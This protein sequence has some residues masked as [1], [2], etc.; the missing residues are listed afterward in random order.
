MKKVTI[1]IV[2][3]VFAM[4]LAACNNGGGTA[5]DAGGAVTPTGDGGATT[6]VTD[7]TAADTPHVWRFWF[8]GTT[9]PY[10]V[11]WMDTDVGRVVQERTGVTVEIEFIV[12]EVEERAA[13]VVAAGDFPDFSYAWHAFDIFRD[14]GAIIPLNDLYEEHAPNIQN[15]W[16]TH[17]N[18]LK[19]PG[20]EILWGLAAM[21]FN[22]P[23]LDYP[24]AGF[25]MRASAAEFHGWR[26]FT[27]PDDFFQAIREYV[28]A[29][30]YND[31]GQSNIGFSGPAEGWR[32]G[33]SMQGGNRLHG[34][35][36]TGGLFFDPNNNWEGLHI[37]TSHVRHDYLV[38]LWELNQ[39]GLLDPEFLS[40]D[41]DGYVAKIASGRVVGFYD[42]FW[43]VSAAFNLLREEGRQRDMFIPMPLTYDFV[44][45]DT[46]IGI[47]TM[48]TRPDLVI[49]RDASD[50]VAIM[51]F[52][53]LMSTEEFQDLRFWGIEGV[54]YQRNA[55]GRRYLTPEQYTERL[56]P[57]FADAT[58]VGHP[59]FA[60]V[61]RFIRS[62]EERPDG[63]GVWDPMVDPAR[64]QFIYSAEEQYN[65]SNMGWTT[66][67]DAFAPQWESPFGF[68]WDI[69]LPA[70]DYDL[71]DLQH[72]LDTEVDFAVVFQQMIMADTRAEFDAIWS[73]MIA[74][75][76]SIGIQPLNDFRVG[77]VRR[78]VAE[79]GS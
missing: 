47:T 31:A 4:V 55:D 9:S 1:I 3:M 70:G 58:G 16:G 59:G 32:F 68:G 14:A 18:R 77:E 17:V 23:P 11:Q 37:D 65:L 51:Q 22:P 76:E 48:A 25:F 26:T 19:E 64:S 46:Y 27:D 7:D 8:G 41:H 36:N 12:G 33:F 78:R 40:Q 5:G 50:P 73:D 63:S 62:A 43:Q 61:P 66:F 57:G 56:Q 28:A 52:I 10:S 67:M 34:F 39:D 21:F 72:E 35:H 54:H 15:L 79:W 24:F 6:T 44:Q 69:A 53:D 20:T 30:P 2:V 13:L 71:L 29:N 74:T 45:T 60:G 75:V 42:E 38:R 49:F